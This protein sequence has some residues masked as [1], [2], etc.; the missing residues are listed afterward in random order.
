MIYKFL[1]ANCQ[2]TTHRNLDI[3]TYPQIEVRLKAVV[4]FTRTGEDRKRVKI[5]ECI[6]HLRIKLIDG[7]FG[8]DRVLKASVGARGFK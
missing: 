3:C 4:V 8:S 2:Q 1:I 7:I 6:F 5:E